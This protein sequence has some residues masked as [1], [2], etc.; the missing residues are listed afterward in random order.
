MS[1]RVLLAT[2]NPGKLREYRALATAGGGPGSNIDLALLPDFAS[3]PAFEEAAPTF[4]ENAAGKAL[5]YS[6]FAHELVLAEDSGL[7]VPSLGGAPGPRSAR[8][9]GPG[10]TD[11]DRVKKL[12]RELDNRF[13]SERQARFVAVAALAREGNAL[14]IFS[15][16]V[17]GVLTREPQGNSGF[18]YDPIFLFEPLGKTFAELAPEEKNR[19]S[20]RARAFGK[21][22]AFLESRESGLLL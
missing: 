22:A 15:D 8:Y 12:L 2:S 3:F 11:Q 16:F 6:R 18:G 10:A 17:E 7:V 20:H 19:Y 13:G 21:V 5:H 14:A 9:G 4:A 1:V